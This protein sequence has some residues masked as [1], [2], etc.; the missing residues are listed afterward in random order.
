MIDVHVGYKFV[1]QDS[2]SYTKIKDYV[3][4]G[5]QFG[6]SFNILFPAHERR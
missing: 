6:V 2:E 1:I 3:N 4:T 5:L